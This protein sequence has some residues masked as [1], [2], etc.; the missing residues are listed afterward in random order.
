MLRIDR[1]TLVHVFSYRLLFAMQFLHILLP[2]SK[3]NFPQQF[4]IIVKI[5]NL[6]DRKLNMH[7]LGADYDNSFKLIVN[8]FND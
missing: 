2:T 1:Y 8:S 4:E 6:K 3:F 7:D 5:Y